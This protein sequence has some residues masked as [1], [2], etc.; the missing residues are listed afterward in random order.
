MFPF[1][2]S[3]L[4]AI[5]AGSVSVLLLS[6]CIRPR[7]P[8]YVEP[9]PAEPHAMVFVSTKF[10]SAPG[11]Y[12][13]QTVFIDGR[14]IV[15]A[16]RVQRQSTVAIRVAPR[17]SDWAFVSRFYHYESKRRLESVSR[18]QLEYYWCVS[19]DSEGRCQSGLRTVTKD[20]MEPVN[21]I[22]L[23]EDGSCAATSRSVFIP[24]RTYRIAYTSVGVNRCDVTCLDVTRDEIGTPCTTATPP[25]AVPSS[26]EASTVPAVS[27]SRFLW[28]PGS[29]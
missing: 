10:V 6:G 19:R 28:H 13:D 27:R 20:D 7:A 24:G 17:E 9:P 1:P 4:S 29:E 22:E 2:V 3:G 15:L 21:R 25:S 8:R 5:V 12:I 11:E 14:R 23:V 26:N 16:S 18:T